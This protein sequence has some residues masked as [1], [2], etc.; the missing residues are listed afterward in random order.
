MKNAIP[1]ACFG[2]AFAA[3]AT[4]VPAAAGEIPSQRQ[5]EPPASMAPARHPG[6]GDA[7]VTSS[8]AIAE[9]SSA[10]GSDP[11]PFAHAM[12]VSDGELDQSRG[13]ESIVVGN[14]TLKAITS[15]NVLNGNYAAGAITLTDGALS[16]FNGIGNFAIN[17]GAQVSLQSGMNLTIN[18]AQ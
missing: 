17:T 9:P 5:S 11:D 2:V 13:G 3:L 8:P 16:N 18:I 4:T 12:Q 14:Q 7:D 15:G 1:I 6:A 10:T